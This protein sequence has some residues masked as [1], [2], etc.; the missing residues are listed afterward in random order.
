MSSAIYHFDYDQF[1][2]LCQFYENFLAKAPNRKFI[3]IETEPA[4][5]DPGVTYNLCPTLF[6]TIAKTVSM[7]PEQFGYIGLIP[8]SL[9][10]IPYSDRNLTEAKLLLQIYDQLNTNYIFPVD[11]QQAAVYAHL[12]TKR[13]ILGKSNWGQYAPEWEILKQWIDQHSYTQSDSRIGF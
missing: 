5:L 3:L 13:T 6:S 4:A 11:K 10:K 2:E 12:G 7:A 8:D 9:K 1:H